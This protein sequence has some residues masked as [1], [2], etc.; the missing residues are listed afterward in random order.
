MKYYIGTTLDNAEAHN[1]FRDLLAAEGHEITFDWTDE[2]YIE[3]L[4]KL[5]EYIRGEIEGI[6]CADFVLILMPGGR[7]TH[8]EL[9]AALALGKPVILFAPGESHM[10][11]GRRCG[12]YY[13]PLVR[14]VST[15]DGVRAEIDEIAR[16]LR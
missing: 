5:R 10:Q 16:R 8:A 1:Q 12:F 4:P 15:I 2:G 7:G 14:M 6:F 3:E 9:G 13:H 11:N